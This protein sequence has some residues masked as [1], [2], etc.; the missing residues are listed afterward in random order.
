M[1]NRRIEYYSAIAM[2]SWSALL[3]ATDHNSVNTSEAFRPMLERGWT[4]PQLATVLGV[5]GLVWMAALWINGH[6]RRSPVFRCICAGGGTVMWSHIAIMLTISG[7]ETS[8]WSSGLALYWP[9]AFFDLASCYRSAADAYFAHLKGKIKD[10]A[11]AQH[12]P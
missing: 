7:L 10:M 6:Y 3:F 2:L 9:L 8:V 4:P 12:E 5:F 1:I 11:A